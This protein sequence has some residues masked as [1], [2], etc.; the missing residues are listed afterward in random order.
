MSISTKCVHCGADSDP[1][2]FA[3]YCAACGKLQADARPPADTPAERGKASV[4]AARR[5]AR[6][7]A[8]Q[9]LFAVAGLY[10]L[11]AVVA[12]MIAPRSIVELLPIVGVYAGLGWWAKR[13][14]I[15][16][17]LIGWFLY[18][19]W[20]IAAIA[21]EQVNALGI[22]VMLIILGVLVWPIVAN[23]QANRRTA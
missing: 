12:T 9:T 11:I 5:R 10:V 23:V 6:E 3:G 13:K 2:A 8:S 20:M 18:V 22:G 15:P 16:A 4:E 14:P 21:R 7:M 17:S 1:A 19:G